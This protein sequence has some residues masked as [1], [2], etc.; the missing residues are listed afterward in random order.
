MLG[1]LWIKNH[2]HIHANALNEFRHYQPI[3][4]VWKVACDRVLKL[5][6]I[7]YDRKRNLLKGSA[8]VQQLDDNTIVD[9]CLL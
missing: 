1:F 4:L 6:Q 2:T 3:K 5:I 7:V 8:V 9:I